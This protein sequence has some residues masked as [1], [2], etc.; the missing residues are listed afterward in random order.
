MIEEGNAFKWEVALGLNLFALLMSLAGSFRLHFLLNHLIKGHFCDI[1]LSL[2]LNHLVV[3]CLKFFV[4]YIYQMLEILLM[5]D[6]DFDLG[7]HRSGLLQR[8]L[9]KQLVIFNHQ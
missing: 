1:Q 8:G 6:L 2:E 4:V 7:R 9:L 5:N 3:P